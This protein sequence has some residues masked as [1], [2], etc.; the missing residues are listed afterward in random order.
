MFDVNRRR[1]ASV[2]APT[3]ALLGVLYT[4]TTTRA[5]QQ[6]IPERLSDSTFWSLV[7]DFSEAGGTFSSDNFVSN[8]AALQYVI[9]ELVT[10]LPK[11]GVYL[12]VGPDQNFTYVA[13]LAPRIA[14]I[15]DIRRG[16][17]LQHLMYKAL[18]EMAPTRAEFLSLLFSRKRPPM[19]TTATAAELL[20]AFESEMP[21]S[22]MYART[23]GKIKQ[24]LT[25]SHHFALSKEDLDGIDYVFDAFFTSGPDLTYSFGQGSRRFGGYGGFGMPTF[26]QLQK[27]TDGQ[28]KNRAYLGSEGS[29]RAL[30]DLELRNLLVPVVGD[31]AGDKAL[32]AVGA[33][34]REHGATISAFYTS[35]VEQYLF[36]QGDQW[37]RFYTNVATLPTD[38]TST[39]IRSLSNRGWVVSQNPNSRSAQLL[40]SIT[41]TI[42]A[43]Q[44]GRLVTYYDVIMLS[45]K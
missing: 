16:A 8:E 26:A 1:M 20:D 7:T 28:G 11:G 23:F 24:Q 6:V 19:D 14:F 42:A 29:Y 38:S 35:N 40:S 3:V 36:Q 2:V 21:D 37:S 22:A 13:A 27:E 39:F 17:L 43:F 15:V 9:P 5:A 45:H 41:E 34:V 12:G 25:V 30:R 10:K 32:R 33:W 31:F 44:A 4:S 18:L